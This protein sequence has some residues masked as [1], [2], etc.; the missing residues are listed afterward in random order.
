MNFVD[1]FLKFLK[2]TKNKMVRM[3]KEEK[4]PEEENEKKKLK[5]INKE[6]KSLT[7]KIESKVKKIEEVRGRRCYLFLGNEITRSIVCDV[8]DDLRKNYSGCN[9]KLDIIIDSGGGDIDAAFNLAA[10]FRKFGNEELIFIVPSW[11]KSA[12]TLLVCG[13]DKILMTPIAELGPLDPQITQ[14]DPLEKRVEQFSPLHIES[15]LS[16]IRKEYENG[17]KYLADKLMERLQFP[18]TLGSFLKSLDIGKQY[19]IKLLSSRMLKD[20][21]E[22]SESVANKLTKGYADHG[23]CINCNEAKEIG[24]T[25]DELEGSELDIIWEIYRAYDKKRRLEKKIKEEE[26]IETI[27]KLPPELLDE[28]SRGIRELKDIKEKMEGIKSDKK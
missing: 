2:H 20:T 5:E 18:L 8:F 24:L 27:R 11:A 23:F 28:L 3:V 21:T 16:L 25:I 12:A 9:G 15:T 14:I 22:K 7:K 17:N 10:L 4:T 26:I 1:S 19:L 13:G 6:I